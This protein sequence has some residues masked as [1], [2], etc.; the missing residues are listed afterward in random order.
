MTFKVK[1]N[2][3]DCVEDGKRGK[4]KFRGVM[5]EVLVKEGMLLSV[6]CQPHRKPDKKYD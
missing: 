1:A 4:E 3:V 6:F 2:N 5:M